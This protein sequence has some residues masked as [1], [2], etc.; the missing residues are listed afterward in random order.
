MLTISLLGIVTKLKVA[1]IPSVRLSTWLSDWFSDWLFDWL[2]TWLNPWLFNWLSVSLS[3]RLSCWL[4]PW[5]TVCLGGPRRTSVI[6]HTKVEPTCATPSSLASKTKVFPATSSHRSTELILNKDGTASS[7]MHGS[8][9][10]C[11][12]TVSG[13][14]ATWLTATGPVGPLWHFTGHGHI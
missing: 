11:S 9:D 10:D 14:E 2:Y 5:L 6:G 4:S 3:D 8:L 1:S 12:L 7:I 13:A